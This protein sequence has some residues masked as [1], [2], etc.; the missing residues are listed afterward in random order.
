MNFLF[1]PVS[2]SSKAQVALKGDP[3]STVLDWGNF[4]NWGPCGSSSGTVRNTTIFH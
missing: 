1:L 3:S 4:L 2:T